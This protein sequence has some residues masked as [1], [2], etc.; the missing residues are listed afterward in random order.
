M[1]P[2]KYRYTKKPVKKQTFKTNLGKTLIQIS[3]NTIHIN[4]PNI[5]VLGLENHQVLVSNAN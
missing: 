3:E 2:K 1:R 5:K 4:A